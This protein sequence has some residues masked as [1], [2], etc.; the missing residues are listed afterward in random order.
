MRDSCGSAPIVSL[1]FG[2]ESH[3][4]TDHE[5]FFSA[6]QSSGFTSA[7]YAHDR[8]WPRLKELGEPGARLPSGAEH[9][10][11]FLPTTPRRTIQCG[12]DAHLFK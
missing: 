3:A 7:V 11:H 10:K 2:F 6:F 1:R 4:E 5:W 12:H 8:T 9:S